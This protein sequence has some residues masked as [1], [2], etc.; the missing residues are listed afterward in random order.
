[1]NVGLYKRVREG[2]SPSLR[3][4][5]W[6]VWISGF[7]LSGAALIGNNAAMVISTG[8]MMALFCPWAV[9]MGVKLR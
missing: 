6:T 1:M 7:S 8:V 5:A 9:V 4:V 3:V 2:L